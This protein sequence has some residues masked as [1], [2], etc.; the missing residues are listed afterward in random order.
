VLGEFVKTQDSANSYG[1]TLE[2]VVARNTKGLK[3]PI[4]MN[5]PFGHGNLLAAMPVGSP[6]KLSV[7]KDKISFGLTEPAVMR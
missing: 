1:L 7:R 6:A 2:D 5:A 3:I 4:I